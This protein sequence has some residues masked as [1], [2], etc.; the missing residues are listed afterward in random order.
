M[1]V[2]CVTFYEKLKSYIFKNIFADTFGQNRKNMS[3]E[4]E[5]PLHH[6][7][8]GAKESI[9]WMEGRDFFVYKITESIV[10]MSS[11]YEVQ[12]MKLSVVVAN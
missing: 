5:F 1:L 12:N 9:V 4:A 11:K 8:G 3:L 7:G 10:V 6:G 2:F